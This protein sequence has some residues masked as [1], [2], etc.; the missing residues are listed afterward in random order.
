MTWKP[1]VLGLGLT[2]FLGLTSLIFSPEIK[3]ENFI[4]QKISNSI[5]PSFAIKR[6]AISLE[7]SIFNS[8]V[9][10]DLVKEDF[11]QYFDTYFANYFPQNT[12]G[13][14]T[15]LA[16]AIP[17]MPLIRELESKLKLIDEF[18]LIPGIESGYGRDKKSET[19]VIGIGQTATI[20]VKELLRVYLEDKQYVENLFPVESLSKL[21]FNANSID[22]FLQNTN[23][24]A[25]DYNYNGYAEKLYA[26]TMINEAQIKRVI[27][28]RYLLIREV[29]PNGIDKDKILQYDDYNLKAAACYYLSNKLELASLSIFPGKGIPFYLDY[30]INGSNVFTDMH[31]IAS[32]NLGREPVKELAKLEGFNIRGNFF[33]LLDKYATKVIKKTKFVNPKKKAEQALDHY[34]ASQELGHFFTKLNDLGIHF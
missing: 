19:N 6:E 22:E 21:K 30:D 23:F 16:R 24:V 26:N 10:G 3:T 1:L 11:I 25:L 28:P 2:T 5:I 29:F 18:H 15:T 8:Y 14:G 32:Y 31:Y 17:H 34:N 4:R 12:G 7:K 20:A 13:Y 27:L 9:E 33:S